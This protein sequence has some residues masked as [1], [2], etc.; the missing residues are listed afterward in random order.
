VISI[1]FSNLA[2]SVA[3]ALAAIAPVHAQSPVGN[4]ITYQGRLTQNGQAI[5]SSAD[6]IFRAFTGPNPNDPSIGN[7]VSVSDMTIANGLFTAALDFGPAVFDGNA[8]WL[9]IS[10]RVPHDPSDTQ[11]YIALS[12]RQLLSAAP[13]ALFA[14]AGNAGPQGPAGPAGPTGPT[15]PAGTQGATGPQGPAGPQGQTGPTGPA[16][17]QGATG[18]QGPIGPPGIPWSLNGTSA[19]YNGGKVG[20]G[21][22]TPVA[23]LGVVGGLNVYDNA[24]QGIHLTSS[25]IGF[26]NSSNEDPTYL[27]SETPTEAHHFYTQGTERVTFDVNGNVNI[28]TSTSQAKLTVFPNP[29]GSQAGLYVR[30]PDLGNQSFAAQFVNDSSAGTAV[31]ATA[32][33]TAGGNRAV[34]AVTNSTT[35]YGVYALA[36]STTGAPTAVYGKCNS[37]QGYAG[38]FDGKGYFSD[39][40]LIGRTNFIGLEY[41]GVRA[42]VSS[43]YGGMYMETSGTL[44]LPFYG[45][46]TNGTP[47]AWH[48]YEPASGEWRLYN[49]GDRLVVQNDGYIGIGTTQPSTKLEIDGPDSDVSFGDGSLLVKSPGGYTFIDGKSIESSGDPFYIHY[50]YNGK[51]AI[52]HPGVA[53]GFVGIGT[54]NPQYKLDVVGDIHCGTFARIDGDLDIGGVSPYNVER[55]YVKSGGVFPAAGFEANGDGF[56]IITFRQYNTEI[57]A[58]HV[59]N[60]VLSYDSFTGSHLAWFD[61]QQ[62]IEYGAL[63]SLTGVNGRHHDK[64]NAEIVYGAVLSSTAN[65]PRCLGAYLGP[66]DKHQPLSMDNPHLVM[67]VGNG[68]MWVTCARENE[69]NQ[70]NIEPGDYLISSDVPGCAMKDDPRRFVVGHVVARA[71]DRV[72]WSNVSADASGLKR[73]R[74]SVLF[75]SFDRGGDAGQMTATIK[76]QQDEIHHLQAQI[77]SMRSEVASLHALAERLTALEGQLALQPAATA[78]LHN[79]NHDMRGSQ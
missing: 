56:D 71:A 7:V 28:N 37:A 35:G 57:G 34:S 63:V 44:A 36:N 51:I 69:P 11:P 68:D 75:Q 53:V 20:I 61:S 70:D 12:P 42:P 25:N 47:R 66:N 1:R 76:S 27:F 3:L 5:N 31:L 50:Q 32:L 10:V 73:A 74:I 14:L 24:N 6:F 49:N 16:G 9:G 15:G 59:D 26:F 45:Y 65:D 78:S 54:D 22:S 41:F 30:N 55:L 39:K 38:Y 62:P 43:G 67:A 17:P 40:T 58:I 60:G 8:R 2:S 52:G 4:G 23:K 48:Y 19:Y 77:D 13:Y 46:A 79:A 72:N 18:P 29:G 64:P 21:T 33:A